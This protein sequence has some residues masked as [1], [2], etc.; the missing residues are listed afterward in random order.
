[1][2]V[3]TQR[4]LRIL[5]L[6][7]T[8][9]SLLSGQAWADAVVLT[10]TSNFTSTSKI[11]TTQATTNIKAGALQA[12]LQVDGWV[13]GANAAAVTKFSVGDG[14][15]GSFNN[16]T[17]LNFD[18]G[19]YANDQVIHINTD[20][21]PDLQFTDFTLDAGWTIRPVGMKALVIRSLSTIVVSSGGVINCDGDAGTAMSATLATAASGGAAHCGGLQGGAGGATS[22]SARSGGAPAAYPALAGQ[23]GA[24]ASVGGGGGAGL[25]NSTNTADGG[26]NSAGA[27]VSTAGSPWSDNQFLYNVG[28]GGGAGGTIG[29]TSNGAGGGAGGGSIYL[30]AVGNITVAG[31]V[32]AN[33]GAGGSGAGSADGG[34]GGAGAGGGVLVF[35]AGNLVI[36]G[37]ILATGGAAGTSGAGG[38]SSAG[39]KGADG[40]TWVTDND[41]APSGSGGTLTPGSLLLI[42]GTID[43]QTGTFETVSKLIDLDVSRASFTSAVANGSVGGGSLT[44]D[45]AVSDFPFNASDADW[46]SNSSLSALAGHRYLRYRLRLISP[47]ATSPAS[48]SSV[49]IQYSAQDQ[50][51]FDFASCQLV[52]AGGSP[53]GGP[54]QLILALLF[55]L[56]LLVLGKFRLPADA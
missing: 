10:N 41:G 45:L 52:K 6:L 53:P 27:Q 46:Q 49:V 20:D 11:E 13:D 4:R 55:T 19:T 39:G 18:N 16:T 43:S 21:Y 38:T 28:G 3:G 22:S 30:Y 25:S 7:I 15:H 26:N 36:T 34:A 42:T 54:G 35:S 33:G 23:P 5:A 2:R 9:S 51:K 31:S 29:S 44:L 56:P 17:Y 32:H 48:A 47:S 14:H 37:A 50:Q 12:P 24:S 8:M 40:R 1:M